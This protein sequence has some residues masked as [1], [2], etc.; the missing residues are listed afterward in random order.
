MSKVFPVVQ[1]PPESHLPGDGAVI[2]K[3]VDASP[4]RKT[5]QVCH[6]RVD[7][8]TAHVSPVGLARREN[9]ARL[10][11]CQ[12]GE[13]DPQVRQ[14]LEAFPVH[15]GLREPHSLRRPAESTFKVPDG[16]VTV[17]VLVSKVAR[18]RIVWV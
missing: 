13:G 3:Q 10:V 1:E 5:A 8:P 17:G 14:D 18:G 9:H 11:G 7:A 16:P 2:E 4:G 6:G 15:G 12:D